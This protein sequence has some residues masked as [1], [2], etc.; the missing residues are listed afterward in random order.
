MNLEMG[1]KIED[2][3][4]YNLLGKG[5]F[6]S[7]YHAKCLKTGLNVAIKM[8]DKKLMQAAG[9]NCILFLKM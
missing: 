2:Y 7:V 6:A 5:G 1:E 4:V 8:I 3:E 9:M